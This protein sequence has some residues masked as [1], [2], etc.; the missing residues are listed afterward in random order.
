MCIHCKLFEDEVKPHQ[1]IVDSM[2]YSMQSRLKE[3][4]QKPVGVWKRIECEG[5]G[6][7]NG[8]FEIEITK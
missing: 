3:P 4:I 2:A 5:V 6:D 8:F 7:N 1:D